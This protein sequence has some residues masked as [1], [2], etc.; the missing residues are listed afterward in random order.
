[1]IDFL[2]SIWCRTVVSLFSR[3]RSNISLFVAGSWFNRSSS[4]DKRSVRSLFCSFNF[5]I[6]AVFSRSLFSNKTILRSCCLILVSSFP[7]LPIV[8]IEFHNI[9]HGLLINLTSLK[10]YINTIDTENCGSS[11]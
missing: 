10:K 4:M 2:V 6:S 11:W 8:I 1:M 5:S 9:L 7:I 3:I